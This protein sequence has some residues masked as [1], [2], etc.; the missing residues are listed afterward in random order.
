M[1][2]LPPSAQKRFL[3]FCC[4]SS[5]QKHFDWRVF[6]FPSTPWNIKRHSSKSSSSCPTILIFLSTE[7]C[8]SSGC[9]ANLRNREVKTR[10]KQRLGVLHSYI[11]QC[12]PNMGVAI[13]YKMLGNSYQNTRHYIPKIVLVIVNIAL[14][15]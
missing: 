12:T 6:F 13:S 15:L 7:E 5:S 4:F 14:T 1:N 3:I 8:Y 9:H 2:N 10:E 11:V